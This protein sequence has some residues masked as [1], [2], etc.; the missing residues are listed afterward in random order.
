MKIYVLIYAAALFTIT[1]CATN[2]GK[3]TH[4]TPDSRSTLTG[5][6]YN[7][8]NSSNI[9]K[10]NMGHGQK[11]DENFKR[12]IYNASLHLKVE[13]PDSA[14]KR[15]ESLANTSKGYVQKLGTY[16]SIIRVNFQ[17][18]NSVIDS[19]ATLGKITNKVISADNVTDEYLDYEIRMDNALK[20]RSRYLELLAKAEDVKAAL[21]VEK[22]LERLNGEIELVKGQLKRIDHL[23]KYATITIH[24]QKK[25]KPGILGYVGI[26]LYK[27]IRWLFVRGK[28]S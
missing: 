24:F 10:V 23:D 26:G 4:I 27:S 20:A 19:I 17:G 18:L 28:V 12:I 25:L 1:G 8:S 15:L 16:T 3:P 22:E 13:S 9:S 11:S 2:H 5:L 7:G 14:N 21:L 6:A